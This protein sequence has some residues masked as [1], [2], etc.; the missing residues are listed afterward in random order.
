MVW[1]PYNVNP[2]GAAHARTRLAQHHENGIPTRYACVEPVTSH[3]QSALWFLC[4][5]RY[6]NG[7]TVW[8]QQTQR[9][10]AG[11]K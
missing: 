9:N 4:Q 7:L 6:D 11:E 3:Q 1:L 5:H 2:F 10:I 8:S